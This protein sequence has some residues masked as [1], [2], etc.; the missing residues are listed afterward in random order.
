MYDRFERLFK[1]CPTKDGLNIAMMPKR[2][3]FLIIVFLCCLNSSFAQE[4]GPEVSLKDGQIQV[5]LSDSSIKTLDYSKDNKYSDLNLKKWIV[6]EKADPVK[7]AIKVYKNKAETSR[8]R[9]V[10]IVDRD[11][12]IK[13]V[14]LEYEYNEGKDKLVFSSDEDF[15][16][17]FGLSDHGGN[18]IYGVN[19][20]DGKEFLVASNA[21]EFDVFS[22]NSVICPL[23][24]ICAGIIFPICAV[25]DFAKRLL[26][27]KSCSAITTSKSFLESTTN[28]SL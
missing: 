9:E 10:W 3:F 23:I 11:G 14:V 22:W 18:V 17:Y 4:K 5:I 21:V 24:R 26:L 19:L 27:A 25:L 7:E 28:L 15:V 12:K 13:S 6:Y 2:I 20:L 8:V 1:Y 16:Y